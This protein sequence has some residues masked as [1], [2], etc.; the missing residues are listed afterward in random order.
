MVRAGFT[1]EHGNKLDSIKGGEY[2]DKLS[3][4]ALLDLS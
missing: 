3:D 1:C 4:L 2:I